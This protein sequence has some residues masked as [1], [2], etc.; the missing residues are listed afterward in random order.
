[1]PFSKKRSPVNLPSIFIEVPVKNVQEQKHLGITLDSKFSF[2]SHTEAVISKSRQGKRMLRSPSKYLPRQILNEMYKLYVRPHLGY[3]D[4]I[5]PI[6]QKNCEFCHSVVLTNM[7]EK[8]ESIQ[9]SAALAVAGA[10]KGTSRDK[11][12]DELGWES[13][14]LR[15]WSRRL[16]LLYKIVN[17]LTSDC[18]GHPIPHLQESNCDLHRRAIG[19]I[20]TRTQGIKFLSQL[21][22]LDP[23]IRP[24]I[25][26]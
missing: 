12:C 15:R 24:F 10:W 16:I 2:A 20:C 4:V 9:Y 1:M 5:Y 23:E 19:Q 11:L 14:S 21:L 26:R 3:G 7:M 18:K 6:P 13:L 17:N 8:L 25:L 22:I